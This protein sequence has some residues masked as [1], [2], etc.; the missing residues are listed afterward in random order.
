MRLNLRI[1]RQKNAAAP[2][3]MTTYQVDGVAPDM[4]FLE[5]LDTLNERLTARRRGAGRLRPRLPRGHL[6]RVQPRHQRRRARPRAHH[7]LPAAH[8]LLPRRR[9]HRRRAVAGRRLPRRPRPRRRPLGVRPHHP[10]RRLRQR[11]HRIGA[12]GARRP[13]AQGRRRHAPSSTPSA[14]AAAPAWPRAP[15]ARRCSS[16]PPRSTT[17]APSRRARPSARPACSTWSPQMDAEGFGGCTLTGECATAC[18]KGIPLTSHHR[19]E[20]GMAARQPQGQPRLGSLATRRAEHPLAPAGAQ[21][22]HHGRPRTAAPCGRSA[23]R[24]RVR[25]VRERVVHHGARHVHHDADP[26]VPGRPPCAVRGTAWKHPSAVAATTH[27]GGRAEGNPVAA[28][29]PLCCSRRV[30]ASRPITASRPRSNDHAR[31]RHARSGRNNPPS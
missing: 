4:S 9:H 18:P 27:S 23:G 5:M 2:G 19:D 7:Q 10:V 14:S 24:S 25:E 21:A 31:F 12:R 20:Q 30:T 8:A 16:P 11:P 3:G 6:R 1:W 22:D 13:R 15:T 28:A 26:A 17:S 29:A